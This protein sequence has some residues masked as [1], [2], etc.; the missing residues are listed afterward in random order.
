ME[1]QSEW[2]L[3]PNV[4]ILSD[5]DAPDGDTVTAVVCDQASGAVLEQVSLRLGQEQAGRTQWPA[6]FADEINECSQYLAA[7]TPNGDDDN[8]FNT[9][10][11]DNGISL[12]RYTGHG[13]ESIDVF[14]TSLSANNWENGL[15]G[16][17]ALLS[18]G[19]LLPD[20]HLQVEVRG[21]EGYL[22][23][24]LSLGPSDKKVKYTQYHWPFHLCS[25]INSHSRYLRAGVINP[26]G[27]SP[28]KGLITPLYSDRLNRLWVPVGSSMHV[29]LTIRDKEGLDVTGLKGRPT[30][31][32]RLREVF[33]DDDLTAVKKDLS[34]QKMGVLAREINSILSC[35]EKDTVLMP[36]LHRARQM[37][38]ASTIEFVAP[39]ASGAI[40]VTFSQNAKRSF[41]RYNYEIVMNDAHSQ[42]LL[43]HLNKGQASE[44]SL[45]S[46][47]V[48]T[49]PLGA[50][51]N[52]TVSVHMNAFLKP[53]WAYCA[54]PLTA[55]RFETVPDTSPE[56]GIAALFADKA[57]T[58]LAA[59]VTQETIDALE[60]A[61]S[62]TVSGLGKRLECE[63]MLDAAQLLLLKETLLPL[64]ES[65]SVAS[66]NQVVV[67]F[68]ADAERDW[69][70][71][72]YQFVLEKEDYT[73]TTGEMKM[74]KA[75]NA[76]RGE[77]NVWT[78]FVR[79]AAGP[80]DR[81][82]LEV[83]KPVRGEVKT[84]VIYTSGEDVF[85]VS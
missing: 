61:L 51:L 17:A 72:H 49:A 66:E 33:T 4:K 24:S 13:N 10:Y 27:A 8:T 62:E 3:L 42:I 63:E 70:R 31:E 56:A 58:T 44:P 53:R 79:N 19:D 23:E 26:P 85:Y 59:G 71:Y 80:N 47:H 14:T 76:S 81:F 5:R 25:Y 1:T 68:S 20:E 52:H 65:V 30:L 74:G 48:W 36:L 46:G 57:H 45:L 15:P 16:E 43:A 32:D 29:K 22:Y 64:P 38:V 34:T 37:L 69:G 40:V 12:W 77:G 82:R 6:L 54:W 78:I 7:G 67:R 55:L 50:H 84:Y 60:E 21:A 73:H 11:A 18:P 28:A 35:P 2:M 41:K 75:I 39:D 9:G 83:Q